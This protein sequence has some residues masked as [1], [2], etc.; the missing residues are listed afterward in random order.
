MFRYLRNHTINQ[1][2]ETIIEIVLRSLGNVGTSHVRLRIEIEHSMEKV[3]D[4]ELDV[5]T[6]FCF[7]T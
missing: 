5:H 2:E 1:L 7:E 6:G 4:F 3:I